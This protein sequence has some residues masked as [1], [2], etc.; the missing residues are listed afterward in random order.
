VRPGQLE[1]DVHGAELISDV[2]G[3][4]EIIE[5]RSLAEALP[6]DRAGVRLFGIP[7]LK[8]ILGPDGPV[9]RLAAGYLGAAARPVRA[10]LFDKTNASNWMV[11]WHQD[12]TIAVRSRL[13]VDGFGPWSI[14]AGRC[15]VAPPFALLADMITL[16]MHL[17]DCDER[18]APLLIVPGSHRF[19]PVPASKAAEIA[20]AIGHESC[21]AQTGD[22]WVYATPILHA[23]ERSRE[24][25]RRRVIQVDYS[26]TALPGGL[27][28]LGIV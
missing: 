26:N 5:L 21:I 10:V 7:E 19:G 2:L 17:D 16:R 15:H 13:E 27:E 20:A 11:G 22:V 3:W 24:P 4:T 6:E 8:D 12:R 9:G 23:S 18:N 1:F 14:K 28:W 25:A